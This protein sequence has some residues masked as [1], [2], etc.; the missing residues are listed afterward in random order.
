MNN[1]RLAE[2]ARDE[3]FRGMILKIEE[4]LTQRVMAATTSQE[5]RA[6]LLAEYHGLQRVK[7]ALGMA[8]YEA[9]QQDQE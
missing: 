3:D 4:N 2:I 8:A 9:A 7:A 1:H 5:D 6:S